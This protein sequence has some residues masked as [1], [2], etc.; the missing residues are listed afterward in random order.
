[1]KREKPINVEGKCVGDANR[2]TWPRGRQNNQ[3]AQ[4]GTQAGTASHQ[5]GVIKEELAGA[6]EC[7]IVVSGGDWATSTTRTSQ[8]GGMYAPT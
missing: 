6:Y 3:G 8:L 2:S 4:E 1:M 7:G 5:V